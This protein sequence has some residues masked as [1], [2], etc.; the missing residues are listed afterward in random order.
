MI[1]SPIQR[2]FRSLQ[3]GLLKLGCLLLALLLG[4]SESQ[5]TSLADLF[6]AADA[7]PGWT[8]ASE[9]ELF[10]SQN[11]YDL[12]DGQAES[13]FAYAFQEVAVRRYQNAAAAVLDVE[14]WQLGAPADAYGLFTTSITGRPVTVGNAGDADP[15]RRLAFWQDRYYVRLRARQELPD[16]ELEGFARA[17][18]AALPTGGER[19]ALVDRLPLDGQVERSTIFFHE[20]IS[21]QD[22]L[23]L[24]D[25]N[26]MG[27]SP[28]TNGVLAGYE[29]GGGRAQLLLVQYPDADAAVAALG[30]LKD[31]RIIG[32]LITAQVSEDLLGVVFGQIDQAAASAL[33]ERALST[34]K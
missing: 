7:L 34:S 2:P 20:E 17:I 24:G 31:D 12:V 30:A 6:P 32:D 3:S 9:V 28:E 13:F 19:P 16:A 25:E 11:L 29:V 15:G 33:L 22:R 8:P 10:D 21:I 23:W 14:I 4:C 1:P 27:L 26:M 18:S 5:P